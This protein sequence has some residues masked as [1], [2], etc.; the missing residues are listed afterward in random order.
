VSLADTPSG[1]PQADPTSEQTEADRLG[2]Y[3]VL[4]LEGRLNP[5]RNPG[6]AHDA[7]TQESSSRFLASVFWA[8]VSSG[9]REPSNILCRPALMRFHPGHLVLTQLRLGPLE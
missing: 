9:L 2:I 7:R 1:A 4:R 8:S 3:L 6:L 5:G